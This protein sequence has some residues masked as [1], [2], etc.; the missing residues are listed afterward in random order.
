ML[1]SHPVKEKGLSVVAR[2]RDRFGEEE[3]VKA[4]LPVIR[5]DPIHGEQRAEEDDHAEKGAQ[6]HLV[7]VVHQYGPGALGSSVFE[8]ERRRGGA[9]LLRPNFV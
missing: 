4:K 5:D 3:S 7:D 1:T 2:W 9:G 8:D 6:E